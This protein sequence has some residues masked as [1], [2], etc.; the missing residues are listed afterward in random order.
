[1]VSGALG[2]LTWS[3]YAGFCQYIFLFD[4]LKLRH[5]PTGWESA[6]DPIGVEAY[7]FYNYH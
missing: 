6:A 4:L 1:M 3:N 7:S 2:N 5:Y